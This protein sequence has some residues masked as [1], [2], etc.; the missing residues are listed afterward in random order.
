MDTDRYARLIMPNRDT[1]IKRHCHLLERDSVL[2][3]DLIQ[4]VM[5]RAAEGLDGMKHEEPKAVRGWLKTITIRAH[6][7]LLRRRTPVDVT[8]VDIDNLANEDRDFYL[9]EDPQENKRDLREAIAKLPTEERLC[10]TFKAAGFTAI[11]IAE[12]VDMT[13]EAVEK[14]C[15]RAGVKI[16]ALLG[17]EVDGD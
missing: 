11:E 15:E 3:E 10:M 7:D 13:A 1:Y 4:E 12:A 5:C 17:M 14:R 16:R 8:L 6:A 2:V 9:M